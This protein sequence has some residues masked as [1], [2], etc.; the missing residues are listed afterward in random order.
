MT[1]KSLQKLNWYPDSE[2]YISLGRYTVESI[3]SRVPD[4]NRITVYGFNS[5]PYSVNVE[6][7]R[8]QT[9]KSNIECVGCHMRGHLFVLQASR[10][11]LRM[12]KKLG[13]RGDCVEENCHLCYRSFMQ[14]ESRERPHFNLY[15]YDGDEFV[16]MTQ[17]HIIP[18]SKGG[19][20]QLSNLQTMCKLCNNEKGNSIVSKVA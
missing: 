5:E 8:L 17:D 12:A 6:S 7:T 9:F 1:L 14:V 4:P 20:D 15:S 2:Q 3:L 10:S 11:T 16:M 13:L 18:K 19:K